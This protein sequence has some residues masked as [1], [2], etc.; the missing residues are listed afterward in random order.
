MQYYHELVMQKSWEEL[1]ALRAKIEFIL[2]GGWAVFLYAKTLKSKDIDI[3]VDYSQLPVLARH[4]QLNKNDRLHKYEAVKG[5]VQIDIYLPHFSQL[6]IPVEEVIKQTT[7]LEGF[8]VIE[9]NMLFALKL[10]TLSQRGRTPKGRKDF[11][12]LISLFTADQCDRQV[13]QGHLKKYKLQLTLVS[14]SEL[15]QETSDLPELGLNQHRFS[16]VKSALK[17]TLLS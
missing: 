13:I 1:T 17:E 15:L 4:Y 7:S 10:F 6:G 14:F 5:E 12:D 2:I 8:T 9:I 16:K 3:I 11:L